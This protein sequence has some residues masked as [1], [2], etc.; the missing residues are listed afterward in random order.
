MPVSATQMSATPLSEASCRRAG[1]WRCH[2]ATFRDQAKSLGRR[3]APEPRG[4]ERTLAA[5]GERTEAARDLQA[6]EA[7]DNQVRARA[8]QER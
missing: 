7:L 2:E 4:P 3:R 6:R 5:A 1:P 8:T